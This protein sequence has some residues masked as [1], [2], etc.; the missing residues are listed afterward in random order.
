MNETQRAT[1][2]IFVHSQELERLP[3]PPQCPFN[4]S[5]AGL[6]KKTLDSMGLLNGPDREQ[7]EPKATDRKGLGRYH[8]PGFLDALEKVS[9]GHYEPEFLDM[10]LG[11]GDCPVFK[12]VFDHAV[13]AT[14]ATLTAAEHIISGKAQIAFNPSG[15]LHHGR[16][17]YASGFC[18]VNDVVLGIMALTD[19]GKKVLYLDVDVHH[20][21]G[22]QNAFYDRNDV[23]TI[24]LH[25]DGRTLFPGTGFVNEVGT[26][27][28]K[29]CSVNV[30]L[31]PGTYDQ[32][33]MK[34]IREVVLPLISVY[35]PDCIVVE[36][37]ADGLAS[38]PLADLNLTNN[39]YADIIA[40]L[41][42]FDRPIL[43]TGG[44]GYD[45]ENT[46]RAWSLAWAALCGQSDQS[47]LRDKRLAVDQRIAKM[48]APAV[49]NVIGAVKQNI[50]SYHGL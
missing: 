41:L 17:D 21:D 35:D 16:K 36:I 34:V 2:K 29:G 42:K 38:D 6:V 13:W 15:G 4:T 43:A 18:Y 37:G 8:T 48:I 32:A 46:V 39:V 1:K 25:Q 22:V 7:V 49:D 33:Y 44:G 45:L 30:P 11:T 50:F 19:A 3:Y 23:M 5:R 9:Q 27:E 20:G 24:S 28:G 31:P 12:G 40:E 47:E 10:G 26:G 14:G